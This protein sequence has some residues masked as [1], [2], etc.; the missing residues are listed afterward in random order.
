MLVS[1]IYSANL[2]LSKVVE[3]LDSELFTCIRIYLFRKKKK[4]KK[5]KK[6]GLGWD[7]FE[8][9]KSDNSTYGSWAT[10]EIEKARGFERE[11]ERND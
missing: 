5:K 8:F 1:I 6:R 7:W 11:R 4:K 10:E 2:L 9:S 3:K